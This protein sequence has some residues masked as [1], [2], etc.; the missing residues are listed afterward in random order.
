MIINMLYI[1]PYTMIWIFRMCLSE[2]IWMPHRI[3]HL[4]RWPW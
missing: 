3:A 2:L 4:Y 1:S